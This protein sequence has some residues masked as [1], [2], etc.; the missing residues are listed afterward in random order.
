VLEVAPTL[1]PRQLAPPA[2]RLLQRHL[3]ALGLTLR[4][5]VGVERILERDRAPVVRLASGDELSAGMVLIAAGIRA[6]VR[7]AR[8]AGLEVKNGIVVDD[9]L[10]TSDPTLFAAGDAAEHQG[11]LSGIW[12]VA[13]GQGVVAGANA[14]GD[15]VTFRPTPPSTRIKV[16]NVNVLSAGDFLAAG[17]DARVVERETQETYVRLVVRDHRLVGANLFG[18]TGLDTMV[19][20]AIE[21]GTLVEQLAAPLADLL[22]TD[23]PRA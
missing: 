8:E 1:L 23:P 20:A 16:V 9:L 3:E 14:A 13:Y 21:N 17:A 4:C 15:R 12:P 18:D 19:A 6:D 11:R 7:L 2:A 5:R 10:Q 22:R